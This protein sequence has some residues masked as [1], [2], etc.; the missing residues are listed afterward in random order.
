[1]KEQQHS[2]ITIEIEDRLMGIGSSYMYRYGLEE[3]FLLLFSF[4]IFQ[5]FSRSFFVLFYALWK[6]IRLGI[7]S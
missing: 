6:G 3:T 1:M 5:F 7:A 4:H 2:K